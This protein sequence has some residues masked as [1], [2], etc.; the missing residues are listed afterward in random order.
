MTTDRCECGRALQ[1]WIVW[2]E[3]FR[4]VVRCECCPNGCQNAMWWVRPE[5]TT[6]AERDELGLELVPKGPG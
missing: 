6:Q 4:C 1:R 2:D 3:T 5:H